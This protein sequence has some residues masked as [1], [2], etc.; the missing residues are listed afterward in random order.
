[1]NQK[2][3][4]AGY[5]NPELKDQSGRIFTREEIKRMKP[6][7]YWENEKAIFHQINSIGI[8]SKLEIENS[9]GVVHVKAYTKSYGTNV[10]EHYRSWPEGHDNSIVESSNVM[11]K[12]PHEISGNSIVS[13]RQT[14][15][16]IDLPESSGKMNFADGGVI[17]GPLIGGI[18]MN[19]GSGIEIGSIIGA[20]A[21][22]VGI[23][24]G[25]ALI[26]GGIIYAIANP[27]KVKKAGKEI[28]DDIEVGLRE[29]GEQVEK[30]MPL[31]EKQ[32][33]NTPGGKRTIKVY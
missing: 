21:G 20:V 16:S 15:K 3:N 25:V 6:D 10:K 4:Y 2:P 30:N 32:L 24:G 17:T 29:L 19:V 13:E 8:P 18:A 14:Q 31:I 33:S 23:V 28:L 7:E 9:S 5:I 11:Q 12:A 22:V 26:I 27:D 1:M